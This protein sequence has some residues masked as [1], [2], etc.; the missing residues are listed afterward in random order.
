MMFPKRKFYGVLVILLI[1]VCE[2]TG[3]VD[4]EEIRRR[5]QLRHL[6]I[7]YANFVTGAGDGFDVEIVRGFATHIG[8]SYTL[9]YTDFYHVMR[10]LLGKDVVRKG[11][12][13]ILEGDYPI[14]GDMI[15]AGFTILPWRQ[16]ALLYSNPTFPSQVLLIAKADSSLRP[17]K[18][19]GQLV[20]DIVETKGLIGTKSLL[21]MEGT[22]LDP[23]N[24]GLKNMG[25]D[26]RAYSK[27]TNLN[28]M[29]PAMLNR[30]A[31][32]TLLDV[33]DAILDLSRWAGQIKVLGPISGHQE[34]AAAFPQ[35]A[36][37]LREAFNAYLDI[38]KAN[39]IYDQ[40][41]DKYYPGIRRYFPEFF[42]GKK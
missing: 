37:R 2:V 17:I 40:L 31:E 23:N 8:V 25:I 12:E 14:K 32:L 29:V 10:D 6:G 7:P 9:V 13:I 27:S 24:Y 15:A 18:G 11:S 30:E 22:C 19:S 4:L 33:P 34:L 21:I 42:T 1:L 26:F 3:A 5:G 41:T 28:E 38:I 16:A 35:D 20:Q 36:P 39:G